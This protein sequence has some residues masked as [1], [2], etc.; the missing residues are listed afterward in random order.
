MKTQFRILT[1][2]VVATLW[3]WAAQIAA[4]HDGPHLVDVPYGGDSLFPWVMVFIT[5]LA[6]GI[7]AAWMFRSG[8]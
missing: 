4:A 5:L 1:V 6:V 2:T 3:L 7:M 8:R